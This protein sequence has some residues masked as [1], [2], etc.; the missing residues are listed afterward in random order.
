MSRT[1]YDI[2]IIRAIE[3][4]KN[5]SLSQIQD[6]KC[7]KSCFYEKEHYEKIIQAIKNKQWEVLTDTQRD[8]QIQGFREYLDIIE[9]SDQHGTLF[10]A[11]IYDSDE[12]WQNP[13]VLDIFI[14]E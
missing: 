2:S 7:I 8:V 4:S 9:F 14:V 3:E 6:V 13:D 12:L 1:S 5:F 10:I 11:L